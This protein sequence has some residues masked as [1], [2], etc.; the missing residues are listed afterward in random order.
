MKIAHSLGVSENT[1]SREVRI[2]ILPH[3]EIGGMT[4]DAPGEAQLFYEAYFENS[5]E[6]LLKNG[7]KLFYNP[8]NKLAMCVTGSGKTNTASLITCALSDW[9]FDMSS[10]Y[11]LSVGCAGG[12]MGFTTLGDVCIATGVC[13]NDLGH[14]ADFRDVS[15]SNSGKLWFHDT[16]YDDAAY[17]KLNSALVSRVFDIVKDTNLETTDLAQETMRRNFPGEDWALRSPS[18][19]RG[20]N[21]SGD[22]F[23]KG[24]YDH[25]RANHIV[26]Y[27]FPEMKFAVS[28]MEDISVAAV[29][30]NFGMLDKC[31]M[32]RVCVN[33]DVFVDGNTPESLW[34]ADC[35]YNAAVENENNETL[36]IFLPAMRNLFKT[37]S[38]FIDAVLN[39]E[40]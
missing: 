25:E 16:S 13:D 39:D 12:A 24:R 40:L 27:Y 38:A 31:V 37:G 8:L 14:T 18:V 34:G 30:D 19:V 10:A 22:N 26:S 9:R 5:E 32:L 1:E 17:K 7:K 28:E 3:F 35:S 23:W 29:A 6:Y 20:V 15:V 21:L 4:G 2:L 33:T 11:I 36:D